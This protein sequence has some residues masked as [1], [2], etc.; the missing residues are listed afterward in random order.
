MTEQNG[1]PRPSIKL[2]GIRSFGNGGDGI[3]I[4]GVDAELENVVTSWNKGKGLNVADSPRESVNKEQA[5]SDTEK[6]PHWYQN[7][8]T[9]CVVAVVSG[10]IVTY[11]SFNL[12][13]LG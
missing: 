8:I 9:I 4:N 7:P 13:W 3:R 6:K 11:I 12:G 5:E 1:N 10:L 2:S